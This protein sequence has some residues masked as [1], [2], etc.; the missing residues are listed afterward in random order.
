MGTETQAIDK[1][2]PMQAWIERHLGKVFF[3]AIPVLMLT[4]AGWIYT[5][6]SDIA[7]MKQKVSENDAQ[8]KALFAC[9]EKIQALTIEVEIC[10]RT[11]KMLLDK[12]K[13]DVSKVTF[14]EI[15]P[16]ELSEKP[17]APKKD[18]EQRVE[19]FRQ[20]QLKR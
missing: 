8:W 10:K 11:F 5:I 4:L 2:H 9:N 1:K 3:T 15:A 16:T 20:Q 17:L 7:V 12:N 19:D 6:G 13:I 18:Y 14:P